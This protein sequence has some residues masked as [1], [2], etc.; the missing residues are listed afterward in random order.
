VSVTGGSDAVRYYVSGDLE[1]EIGPVK[2]PKFARAY[3]DS[4]GDPARDEEIFPEAFQRQSVRA[5]LNAAL[6]PK[7]DLSANAG[8]S[9]RNQRLPQSDNNTVSIYSTG[10]APPGAVDLGVVEVHA[11]Q[12]EATVDTLM[13]QFVRKAAEILDRAERRTFDRLVHLNHLFPRGARRNRPSPHGIS[14]DPIDAVRAD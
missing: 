1:N 3:L 7:F 9:N 6:S 10:Q 14:H 12:Q 4:V 5:N 2:M 8:W 13:P 11:Q